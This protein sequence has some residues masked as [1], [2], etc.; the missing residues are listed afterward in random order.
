MGGL[1][2]YL[3]EWLEKP[4]DQLGGKKPAELLGTEKGELELHEILA[5]ICESKAK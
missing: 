3:M 5:Q 4:Q 2:A 1:E